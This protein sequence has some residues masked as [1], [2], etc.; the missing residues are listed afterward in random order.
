MAIVR[1]GPI[2]I[3]V[4]GTV[5]GLTFSANGSVPYVRQW[6]A[7]ARRRTTSQSG[8]RAWF[9]EIRNKWNTLTPAQVA[10]WD[11]LA[12]SPPEDDY[13]PFGQ[14]IYLSGSA[15]FMRVNM[16]RFQVGQMLLVAAPPSV[17]VD[18]PDTF[19]LSITDFDDPAPTDNFDYT[20]GDFAGH[21]AVLH[22]SPSLSGVRNVQTT[23]YLSV[24]SDVV[25]NNGPQDISAALRAAFGWLREGQK[26]FGRLWRQSQQGIRSTSLDATT[27][28]L[29]YP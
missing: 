19:T 9:A 26:V 10:G 21:Y 25:P 13:D 20:T 14:L 29:P 23:G 28:V 18:P 6:A 1:F 7:P 15:W 16:R 17:P 3:G 24:W 5:G 27:I 11:A 2:V 4:R 22:L 12:A 8:K